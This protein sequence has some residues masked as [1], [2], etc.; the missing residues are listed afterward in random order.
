MEQ[1]L[2]EFTRQVEILAN[3]MNGVKYSKADYAYMYGVQEITINRDLGALKRRGIQ[4]FSKNGRVVLDAVPDQD[5]LV[6]F[7]SSYIPFKLNAGFFYNKVRTLAE[8]DCP[9]YFQLLTFLSKAVTEKIMVEMKYQPLRSQEPGDY[10]ITPVRLTHDGSNWILNAYKDDDKLRTF[11]LS[12]IKSIEL[13]YNQACVV[14]HE[15]SYEPEHDI[16]LRFDEFVEREV[17]EKI[18][19][20]KYE[21]TRDR[22]NRVI[23]KTRQQITNHLAAWCISWWDS[24]EVLEPYALKQHIHRM[25]SSFSSKNPGPDD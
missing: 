15:M 18:W 17:C 21:L 3:C 11:Y 7:A 12:R 20:E 22:Q 16:V 5:I 6:E 14:C 2:N 24:L 1:N 19:F 23:L 4:I 25:Y 10:F 8:S 13:V 9:N